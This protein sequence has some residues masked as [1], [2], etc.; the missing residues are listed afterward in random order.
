MVRPPVILVLQYVGVNVAVTVSFLAYGP[1]VIEHSLR[2]IGFAPSS[3]VGKDFDTMTDLPKL[4]EA[5]EIAER[6]MAASVE[7]C[8]GYI[9][10]KASQHTF[11]VSVVV[12]SRQ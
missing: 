3:A 4:L 11:V 12:F 7:A 10:Q 2:S 5:I 1:A 9:I 6:L 8:K